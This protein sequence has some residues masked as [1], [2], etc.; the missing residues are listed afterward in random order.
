MLNPLIAILQAGTVTQ[1]HLFPDLPEG[2]TGLPQATAAPCEG[3]ACRRCETA[4]PTTA[5][6][7]TDSA[8]RSLVTLDRGCCI[9]CG[10]C[11]TACPTGTLAEDRSTATATRSRDAL[12]LTNHPGPAQVPPAPSRNVPFLRS[13]HI[14]EVSTGCNA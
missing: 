9:G 7:V 8:S 1:R 3:T 5:I 11:I 2:A 6:A 10:A 13:L 12:L 4:C 14:R